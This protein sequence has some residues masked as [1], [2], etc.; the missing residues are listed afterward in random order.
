M[1]MIYTESF[2]AFATYNGSDAFDATN[3]AQRLNF[4]L[5]LQRAG[6][7][8][9]TSANTTA[10]NSG[11]FMVRPDP[12]Y[13]ERNVLAH[14]SAAAAN[15]NVGV[16]AAFRKAMPIT[17]RQIIIGFSVYIPPDYVA[18][19]NNSTVAVLRVNAALQSDASWQA[20]GISLSAPKEVMRIANDLSVRWGTDAVQ[21]GRRLRVGA[22]NYIELRIDPT[23]VSAW[24]DDVLVMSKQASVIPQTVGF[25]FENNI[26]A[27]AGGTNMS[28]TPGRWALGNMYFMLV[29]GIAPT[30]RLGPTTRII[31]V[32]PKTDV[33]VRFIRPISAPSNASVAGQDIVDNPAQQ[34]QSTT[35]G[36]F[37]TYGVPTDDPA[38]NAI[39]TM[40]MVHTVVTKV[41]AA[42]LEADPHKIKP[43]S[44]YL[45][46]G[47]GADVRPRDWSLLTGL[48]FTRTI[49][50]M[51]VRPSDNCVFLCGDGEMIYRS[52]PNYDISQWTKISDTG[53][54]RN[55]QCMFF[56]ADG[57]V[58]FGSN[59]TAVSSGAQTNW[60]W[61]PP[62]TDTI[63]PAG[64]LTVSAGS[65]AM[66]PDGTRLYSYRLAG[67]A[68]NLDVRYI[69]ATQLN[70]ATPHTPTWTTIAPTGLTPTTAS[71]FSTVIAKGDGS[72]LMALLGSASD[73]V[74]V[75]G[76]AVASAY[77]ARPHGDSSNLYSAAVW[78]GVA[79]LIGAT[80]SGG[81]NG[82]PQIR[83]SV[84]ASSF[85]PATGFG[86][87][88]T[89][90]NSQLRA[91][92]A[93]TA[94]QESM[95]VGDAGAMVMSLDGISWRQLPRLTTQNLYAGVVLPTGDFLIGGANGVMLRSQV[96]GTETT[97]QPL[98]G[99]TMAYGTSTFNPKTA[100]PW[101]PAEAA[102]A[103][104]GVRLTS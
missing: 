79:F 53:A 91:G 3:N 69:T 54:T 52:G 57:G 41:L 50:A 1:S 7:G 93:N 70:S 60:A 94:T 31:A 2:G 101:T 64:S 62:G 19:V 71:G 34:L 59:N 98:A 18:N 10:D 44:K 32:R 6:F 49:R 66:S 82:A 28:G 25:I 17:D 47:E 40:A 96:P 63:D 88:A 56:R 21:S 104:F 90:A 20:L 48:P 5:A 73:S 81:T 30:Q 16:T 65:L 33:D 92:I 86:N 36:D 87:T 80:S 12:L 75:N 100:A 11:G 72:V 51:A 95:F 4:G 77:V 83:R 89:G 13:P 27:G 45:N 15:V 37:D 24:I 29:D 23:N 68:N 84:D 39:R 38:A 85:V 61:L 14:S 26:N 76:N 78:D 42:N 55:Y 97:L 46:S 9:A 102:D 8:Y 43:Y 67:S 103:M 22:V 58:L 74:F 35:V 99:Y